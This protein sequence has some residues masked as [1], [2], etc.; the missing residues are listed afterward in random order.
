M[1][2]Q[3]IEAWRR[4]EARA[5]A[6]GTIA[7]DAFAGLLSQPE[8]EVPARLRL[9]ALD[10]EE[11]ALQAATAQALA[12]AGVPEADPVLLLELARRLFDLGEVVAGLRCLGLPAVGL[13]SDPAVHAGAGS[14]LADLSFY[15]LALEHLQRAWDLG[16]RT[17]R[18]A[19][20]CGM[21][22]MYCGAIDAAEEMLEECLRR[23]RDFMPAARLLSTLRRQTEQNNH[24]DRLRAALQRIGGSHP[25]VPLVHYALFKELDD[26]GETGEAWGH[27]ERG[28]VARRAQVAYDEAAELGLFAS[29]Q[30]WRPAGASSPLPEAAAT[31]VF[32]V[33][34]PRSG[35]T[36]LERMLAAHPQVA[37]AGELR[38][39]V[40]QLRWC[41]DRL[42]GP[43]P[44]AGLVAASEGI[45]PGLLGRRYLEHAAWRSGGR[46]YFIDKLP[47]NFLVAGLIAAALPHARIVHMTRDPM[48]VCFS[49]LKA[50]FAGAYPHSYSQEEMARHYLRY[51]RLMVHWG[52]MFE[53]RILE[54]GYESL[55]VDPETEAR[56]VLDFCG[57]PWSSE[58]IGGRTRNG[59]VGTASTVQ[60]REPIHRRYLGQWRVYERQL[61]QM[62]ALLATSETE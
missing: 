22:R 55:V 37:D 9:V 42:G 60:V 14:M 58:V 48:D 54:V 1:Q 3:S 31:P 32:I 16:L 17:P 34:M 20:L 61:M 43:H 38:D 53:G 24:I 56:R 29:L 62:Q 49:N 25:F 27:L 26:L 50:L 18:L 12:A 35:T 10:L 19:Y 44:D 41:S 13:A 11:G 40:C 21:A 28:M 2:P 4:A 6:G 7:R 33:G 39:F 45:D 15:D 23:D 8:L 36:L 52:G 5:R 47:T 51:R 57:L 46:S 59:M 30:R